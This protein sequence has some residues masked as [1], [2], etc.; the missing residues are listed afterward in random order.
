MEPVYL[1]KPVG[2]ADF[3]F[4][5]P[6]W[7]LPGDDI[8]NNTIVFSDTWIQPILVHWFLMLVPG[9]MGI[10]LGLFLKNKFINDD[11]EYPFPDQIIQTEVINVL[12]E[13]TE[14]LP[15]FIKSAL[16]GFVFSALTLF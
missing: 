12:T 3:G 10:L 5:R 15:L 2:I 11:K 16:T 13:Q 8:I 4:D 1:P 9:V 7:L 6:A 14:K